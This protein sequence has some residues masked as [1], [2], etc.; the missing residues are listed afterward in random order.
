MLLRL[1]ISILLISA[2]IPAWAQRKIAADE[3]R[4]IAT[5]ELEAVIADSAKLD[6]SLAL[7]TVRARAASLISYFDPTRAETIFLQTWKFV[8]EQT[9]KNFDKD[10]ARL[11]ILKQL[12]IRNPKLARRLLAEQ[13]Q[14]SSAESRR[15]GRDNASRL[16]A[17]LSSQLIE[18]DPSTAAALLEES[19]TNNP[20]PATVMG[21]I[22]L[23]DKDSFLADYVALRVL[24][25][26]VF[27]PTLLSLPS[28]HLLS[29]YIFPW[30]DTPVSTLEAESSLQL[31]QFKF[32]LAAYDVLKRSLAE[33][34]EALVRDQ[35]YAPPDLQFRAANQAQ[36]AAILAA[37][38]P[39]LQPSSAAE[40]S[41]IA[42]KLA[43]QVPANI[44]ELSRFSLARLRG[45]DLHSEDPEQ[46]FLFAL[47]S[48]DFDEARRQLDRIEDD[49]KR[50]IYGQLLIKNE[51]KSRLAKADVTGALTV[52]RKLEDQ[53]TRLVMYLDAIKAA[54]KKSDADLTRILIDEARLLLPQTGKNGLHIRALLSFASQLT[55]PETKDDAFEFLNSAVAGINALGKS[56][57]A[58]HPPKSLAEAAMA[59]LND[60]ASLLDAP[61]MEQ[62]FASVGLIDFER[63]LMEAKKIETRSVRLVAR[64]EV[65]QGFS[66]R[67]SKRSK[68]PSESPGITS[69]RK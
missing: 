55:N 28:L 2:S 40:L 64:L 5:T 18:I 27:Q 19:L 10:Q 62:A 30:P 6:D 11:Q 44:S 47:S 14:N 42:N 49:K 21:L 24:D 35:H 13:P 67:I 41:A 29:A 31:L 46:N 68:G 4:E 58:P 57:D 3:Q 33:T 7:V 8:N 54:K 25:N 22:G 51:A 69:P 65:L 36:I 20:T 37:L 63:G 59:E 1:A 66:K 39:R 34:N 48:A 56:I 32:F 53:S 61:E 52:I 50:D 26:L 60:P 12:F 15:I 45:S 16:K 38:A 43:S 17:K 23:R 9:D